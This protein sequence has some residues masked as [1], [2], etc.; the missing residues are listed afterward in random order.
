MRPRPSPLA[1]LVACGSSA[2]LALT[3][4]PAPAYGQQPAAAPGVHSAM[5]W[6]SIGPYRGGRS[7][8]STGVVGDPLTYYMG[9]VGGGVWKTM[10]AGTTWTN[11][12]D[13][14]LE[15]SSVGAIAVS[16]SDP[17]VV[18]VGMG[19]HAIRGVMTSHGDGVYKSTDAGRTWTHLGLD[20]TRHISR[21]R[22]HPT[23]PDVVY[24]AAQGAA[25]GANPERGIYRSEDGG[26][27][28]D[29]VL[30]VDENSGASE[31][32]MDMTNPRILYASF[33]D[34]RRF[35]WQVRSGGPGSGFWKSTDGGDTWQEINDGLPELMGKT[36]ID[37]SR[38]NPDRL[39]AMVEADPGGGL[40]RSDDAGRSWS[41]VSDL[42]T[43]RARAWYYINVFADPVDEETVY[44][45]NA[46]VMKSVDGGRTFS[47][48]SVPHGDNHDLWINPSDNEVMI[49]SND[50]GANVSF[51]GGASWST[52]Q[53]QP[54]AQF[55]RVN[56]DN[57]FPYHVYGGQQDN[58]TVAIASRGQGGVTWKDW[59]SVGG[60]ESARPA[61]DPDDPRFVYA[62]CYMGIISEYDHQSGATRDVAAYPVMPAA[63]QGREMKYRY[64]WSAPIAVSLHDPD[65]I[66][67]ASNHVVRSR[68]RGMT[69]EEISP[70]LTRDEDAK[71]GYGGGPITGEGAGG[72]IYGTIY[73][74]TESPH[75]PN[76]IWT[77]SDDGLVHVTRD[78]GATWQN[79]TPSGWGEGMIN[80]ITV[81]PHDPGT[82]YLS[83][84]RY[85][86]ND[87]TPRA[88]VTT[89]YGQNWREIS[90][91]F[92][93]EAWVH[94]VREDPVRPG[95]LYAGTETGIYVSFDG[96]NRWRSLQLNLPLTPINDLIVQD[97]ENDLVV[98]TSGRS[99]WILD[100]LSPLQQAM[101]VTEGENHL[102]APRHAYRLA[103]GGGGGGDEG[104]NP[105]NG[106]VIDFVLAEEWGGGQNDTEEEDTTSGSGTE[107]GTAASASGSNGAV[108]LEFLTA[109][110]DLVRT[111]S[112]QPDEDVSPG[113]R[114][115]E[116]RSGANRVVWD[117]RHESI[118]NIPGAYVFGS[119]AGRRVV[120]GDYQ[121][122]LTVGDWSVTQ[123][124][125]VRADPRV[126][127]TL[128]EYRAQDAF[129]AEVAAELTAIHRAVARN[130]DVREQL[131]S[132]VRRL[133]DD[134]RAEEVVAAG[135]S[136]AADLETVA[137]SLY[138]RRTVDGQ[139]VINFPTR[140]KFQYVFLHGNAAGGEGGVSG[141]SRDVL[142]DLRA[143]W[144]VHQATNEELLGDRLEAFNDLARQ[145]GFGVVILPPR[146]SRPVS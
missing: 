7:V 133:E 130:D 9:T 30:F 78:G 96:G 145:A 22:V 112:T 143:R 98:A 31:L 131:E 42:W 57:R 56:V 99:F 137:D 76:T 69:W 36:G 120:P 129:V 104:R 17:N 85:K 71:Q 132:L 136:L 65:V 109:A 47:N 107:E 83:F 106:A 43:I 53:N 38:A 26:Q 81:S 86:F 18:Y 68:D 134:E 95:L 11:V 50:G 14:Q 70:D 103:S 62:G 87:F 82:A 28:W 15:T 2:L 1:I 139:T 119:L 108:T 16:E 140:L 93:D 105:P 92:A 48:V 6:R 121:V 115:L 41:L 72:E 5:Q 64:N 45:L 138:Q 89:N 8:A 3:S 34:H 51:N 32:A 146:P 21:I 91:G 113:A 39:W 102:F 123:P 12:S 116:V 111:L 52:Q 73:A 118:P 144:T 141:G 33:W 35:P 46:P 124:L 110:G 44:V 25:H 142:R 66:Y 75:D 84:N 127:A 117:L 125:E 13:G 19:E 49:N 23:N 74:F 67:H 10:D 94:V 54:T 27:S 126:D 20:R 37:V 40:F 4:A 59:Y 79:V 63:L 97:R 77:G 114:P 55:Y 90:D 58:S 60:C 100:D 135:D 101:D 128:A 24:V 29:L 80:E 61:F 88:Y 122:R